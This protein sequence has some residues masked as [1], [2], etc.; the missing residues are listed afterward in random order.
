MTGLIRVL[1]LIIFI[2]ASY[3]SFSQ[4]IRKN[5]R[6]MG[7]I[8][9][10]D[11]NNALQQFFGNGLSTTYG[12]PSAPTA[13]PLAAGSS[14]MADYA[15]MHWE[16]AAYYAMFPEDIHAS[17]YFLPFHRTFLLDWERRL[18]SFN[19][20]SYSYNYLSVPYWDW[21]DEAGPST[22]A[23][24]STTHPDF[25][26]Y[27]FLPEANFA[28]TSGFGYPLWSFSYTTPLG[29]P[30]GVTFARPTTFPSPNTL[31]MNAG[32]AAIASVM[33]NN[34]FYD[35]SSSSFGWQL[36]QGPHNSM[37]IFIGQTPP[38]LMLSNYSPFDPAFWLHHSMVDKLWQDWEDVKPTTGARSLQL[39]FLPYSPTG[40]G[41]YIYPAAVPLYASEMCSTK[42]D[43]RYLSFDGAIY[44]VWFAE[45]GKVLI[46]GN[47][48]Q[49]FNIT[50]GNRTYRYTVYNSNFTSPAQGYSNG[51]MY[52]G[53]I[54]RNAG[55]VIPD[56]K[57]GVKIT[58]GTVNFRAGGS[59]TFMPG[60][61]VSALT[62]SDVVHAKTIDLPYGL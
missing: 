40:P 36:E 45:N 44:D 8:E 39:T 19:G 25:F 52:V 56:G 14:Y 17:I 31:D 50:S 15:I 37:H 20:P 16:W 26:P 24:T 34:V 38:N 58:G 49:D 59:I 7:P 60:F 62:G 10:T 5:Y 30:A 21:R 12:P 53:D 48:F 41:G 54:A 2:A 23:I 28:G 4:S 51:D 55:S 1:S 47:K 33:A 46:N 61:S 3:D 11:Y 27:S 43:S 6:E 42:I 9:K 29:M 32:P 18:K 22:A 57:G 13:Y 35:F